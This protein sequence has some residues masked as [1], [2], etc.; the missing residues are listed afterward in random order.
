MIAELAGQFRALVVGLTGGIGSGKSTIAI[1]FQRQNAIPVIDADQAARDVVAR[2][3]DALAQI[4]HYFGNEAVLQDS[5]LNRSWLRQQVFQDNEKKQWLN[6]LLHPLIRQQLLEALHSVTDDYVLL[7]APLLF[8]NQLERF[9]DIVIVV[10]VTEATQVQRAT[11]RDNS[12]VELIH[13]VMAAQTPR[14]TRLQ[15]ATMV[16]DNELPLASLPERVAAIHQQLMQYA[17]QKQ[18]GASQ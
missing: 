1:E 7:M 12:S 11:T 15:K 14:A 6:E 4:Q 8:E 17:Q 13:A 16:I 9:C 10:D 5:T 18:H 2:G 3:S